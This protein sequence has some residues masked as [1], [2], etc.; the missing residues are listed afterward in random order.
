M[1]SKRLSE[2]LGENHYILNRP[3]TQTKLG[4]DELLKATN[5]LVAQAKSP[6]LYSGS[7]R[8]MSPMFSP[9]NPSR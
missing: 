4:L 7:N 9:T 8:P 6:K 1:K 3:Q 5:G 2:Y